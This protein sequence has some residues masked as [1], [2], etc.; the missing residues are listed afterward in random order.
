MAVV[1]G[2]WPY[3]HIVGTMFAGVRQWIREDIYLFETCCSPGKVKRLALALALQPNF[4]D[5]SVVCIFLAT[6]A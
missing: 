5:Q 1:A 6:F 3:K 4:N 2:V